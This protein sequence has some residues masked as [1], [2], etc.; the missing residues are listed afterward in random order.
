[1]AQTIVDN[2]ASN[3]IIRFVIVRKVNERLYKLESLYIE[4]IT[5][6]TQ[7][8]QTKPSRE[9]N[10]LGTNKLAFSKKQTGIQNINHNNNCRFL[11]TN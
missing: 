4:D 5:H 11:I 7:K 3:N 6:S 1:M 10:Q 9:T 8:I 2:L